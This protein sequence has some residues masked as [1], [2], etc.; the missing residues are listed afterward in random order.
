MTY[1]WTSEA[2]TLDADEVVEA[3]R[4][5]HRKGLPWTDPRTGLTLL[6]PKGRKRKVGKAKKAGKRG[7]K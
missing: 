3:M 6:P 4:Q 5:N 2:A 7:R 1:E